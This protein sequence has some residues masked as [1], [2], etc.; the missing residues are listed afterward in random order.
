MKNNQIKLTILNQRGGVGKTTTALNLA[1]YYADS[2]RKTLLV[3]AD[4]QGSINTILN[5]K[6]EHHLAAF[7][8]EKL[9]L[10]AC[11]VPAAENLDVLCGSRDTANAETKMLSEFARERLFEGLFGLYDEEYE[12]IIID[13]APSVS[14]M[15][16]C[17]AVYT[18]NVL[19]PVDAEIVS[20][21]GAGACLSFIDVLSKAIRSPI[22]PIGILPTKVDKRLGMTQIIGTHLEKLAQRYNVPILPGVRVDSAVGKAAREKKFLAN[23][24]KKS[25]AYEDYCAVAE[26][27][28]RIFEGGPVTTDAETVAQNL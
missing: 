27:L 17:A 23:Y 13:V 25:K 15:Q 24:D 14:L 8:I 26:A 11:T 6:P 3:D 5:L 2:G 28:I 18:Q 1:R 19:I 7:L 21:S 12:V 20:L 10:S 9:A 22:R 16:A 4:P